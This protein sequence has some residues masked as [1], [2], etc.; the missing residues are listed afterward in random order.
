VVYA[1]EFLFTCSQDSIEKIKQVIQEDN[2][3]RVVVASC[4]PRTHRPLF[5]ETMRE[6][7]LNRHLFEMANIRDQCT[8]VHMH[9]PEKATE[10]A[11]DLVRMVVAKAAL[12]EPIPQSSVGVTKAALVAGGG[13]SGM[14]AALVLAGQGYETHIIE[15][16][17]SLGG[18]SRRIKQGLKGGDVQA[19][20]TELVDQVNVH[21]LIKVHT[22]AEIEGVSGYVGNYLTRLTSG[23]EIKH[24]VAIVATG[25][26]EYKPQEYSYDQD[27]RVLTQLEMEEVIFNDD[28]RVKTA[29]NVVLIQCVGSRQEDRIY[30]SRICCTKSVKLAL[31]IK[32]INPQANVYILYRDM[33][34]YSFYEEYYQQAREEGIIFVRFEPDHKPVVEME[35]NRLTVKVTDHI[36]GTPLSLDADMVGLAAA[37]VPS[38][39][40]KKISQFFKVPLNSDGFFLEAHMK[41]RPVDFATEGIFMAGTAH[42]PKNL[43]ECI[44][45]AKA[46]AGRASTILSKNILESHGVVAQVQPE[47]CAACLTCVRL[48]PY[49]AP[50]VKNNRVEIEAV[51]CQG[52]GICAGECPN[53]AIQLQG[54]KDRMLMAMSEGLF[55]EV[56]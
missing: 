39:T 34:T 17:D 23:V 3:N 56:G 53:K 16:E 14:T 2:L 49:G 50:R 18:L 13:I 12:L 20:L 28:P 32:E 37:I 26:Q 15:K 21:S 24:G 30:C 51:V 19:H 35:D 45:Q 31:K 8:W 54:Y 9:E 40:N 33:R 25:A 4:S 43:E 46:A 36:L 38:D 7:G 11:I 10:K 27:A 42:G 5:Q 47:K 55:A 22:G 52:C 1:D 6:A 29:Q 41:L 44:V 48:C